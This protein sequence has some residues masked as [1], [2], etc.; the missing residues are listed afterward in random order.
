MWGW[1]WHFWE[2]QLLPWLDPGPP[3]RRNKK[4]KKKKTTPIW[5][6]GISLQQQ[7]ALF[8]VHKRWLSEEGR[9]L[10]ATSQVLCFH[11][12]PHLKLPLEVTID[13]F[14]NKE[15]PE[16]G[17]AATVSSWGRCCYNPK[18]NMD[19]ETTR[20]SIYYY[21]YFNL[22]FFHI[23]V[24]VFNHLSNVIPEHITFS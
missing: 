17:N 23:D 4:K 20:I 12:N 2:H 9:A 8:C 13:Q 15:A 14:T 16:S 5:S 24:L 19:Q 11:L 6:A 22:Y 3:W 7:Q 1:C 10:S 21:Y 18:P